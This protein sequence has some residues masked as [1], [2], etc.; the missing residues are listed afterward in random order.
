EPSGARRGALPSFCLENRRQVGG[1]GGGSTFSM[2][3]T[4]P[5]SSAWQRPDRD[6]FI[7][8]LGGSEG[9]SDPEDGI[10]TH[11]TMERFRAQGAS[12]AFLRG[13][14]ESPFSIDSA[15]RQPIQDSD[16]PDNIS[17]NELRFELNVG[18]RRGVWH[19]DEGTGQGWD[20]D[21]PEPRQT[22]TM[23]VTDALLPLAVGGTSIV[24][25]R[26]RPGDVG[27]LNSYF[28]DEDRLEE[29]WTTPAEAIAFALGYGD[30][31]ASRDPHLTDQGIVRPYD[32]ARLDLFAPAPF[33]D[34]DGNAQFDAD[35]DLRRYPGIPHAMS[36]LDRFRTLAY[37]VPQRGELLAGDEN[38]DEYSFAPA[39]PLGATSRPVAGLINI[40]TAPIQV[41]RALPMFSR[42]ENPASWWNP[43]GSF[44][45]Y[46][47]AWLVAT[48]RDRVQGFLR[49]S[50]VVIDEFI[51]EEPLDFFADD[52]RAEETGIDALRKETGFQSVGELMAVRFDP[53]VY[54]GG[55]PQAL[56][57][58]DRLGRDNSNSGFG[59]LEPVLYRSGSGANEPRLADGVTDGYDEQM[60]IVAAAMNSV[61]VRSDVFAAWIVVRGYARED[62]EGLA[63][64]DP[65]VPTLE[66]RYLMII[67][68]SNVTREGD[69]PRIL[70]FEE[71]PVDRR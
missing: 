11:V 38:E 52:E 10:I 14:R 2:N 69:R 47:P 15:D 4:V 5:A 33:V 31:K 18:N 25:P 7:D 8:P 61:T 64:E 23:R 30:A 71:L 36:V 26:L 34:L 32:R 20:L 48:Y 62:V 37:T 54:G 45:S 63:D 12:T 59:G 40:N 21:A 39:S 13:L 44:Q 17:F 27:D 60:K 43:L 66:R 28:A 24:D 65:M 6:D 35:Q 53:E 41:L 68:R 42:D 56:F 22:W 55:T 58:I 49:D 3:N 50:A 46:D 16:H 57:S 70:A 67:D 9:D 19:D 1:L 29:D 51:D